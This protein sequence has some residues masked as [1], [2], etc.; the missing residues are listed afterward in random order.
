MRSLAL[1]MGLSCRGPAPTPAPAAWTPSP[2][3][4]DDL[5][6]LVMVDR[7]ADGLPDGPGTTDPDDP[8]AFHGGDLQGVIDRLDHL[9]HIGVRTVWLTPVTKMRTE[10]ISEHG[11]FHGYWVNDPTQVEPRFGD[12][13]L[14]GALSDALHQ[15]GMRLALDVVWNHQGWDAPLRASH[16]DWFHQ[17]GDI[18]DWDDPV[19]LVVNDVHGLPDLAVELP[20]VR[21]YLEA[22]TDWLV[23]AGRP[24]ALRVDAVRHLPN[25]FVAG[26]STRLKQQHGTA[27]TVLAEDFQGDAL[28]LARN[29]RAAGYDRVFDFPLRYALIDSVCHGAG[30]GRLAGTLALDRLYEDPATLVT[31]L[32]NHDLPRVA[33]ECGGD[34][35]RVALALGALFL[36]RGT[37]CLS[38]GTEQLMEGAG[39]PDNRQSM[40]W[41]A[42]M[43][44]SPLIGALARRRRPAAA[45]RIVDLGP[46]WIAWQTG[47]QRVLLNLGPTPVA[48]DALREGATAAWQLENGKLHDLPDESWDSPLAARSLRAWTAPDHLSDPTPAQVRVQIAADLPAGTDLR[49][50]GAGPE[51][52]HWDPAQAPRLTRGTD[53]GTFETTLDLDP[54]VPW[55]WKLVIRDPAGDSWERCPNRIRWRAASWVARWEVCEP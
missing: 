4:V 54:T 53:V 23:D 31:F 15:R 37:P 8:Q 50:V 39:E 21:T 22:A 2:A 48:T 12:A 49:L 28:A 7:F 24:D 18:T 26:M 30:P 19:Q 3:P 55:E 40:A 5:Y 29:Q 36:L 33:T 11:A 25:E 6:Y 43:P 32:D 10:K 46:T 17:N 14:L 52:G 44:L 34:R 1:L 42:P 51:L 20:A 13:A 16:P 45:T 9:E 41:D 47:T 38:W 27:F 35:D